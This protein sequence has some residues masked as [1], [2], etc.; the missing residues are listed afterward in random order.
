[1]IYDSVISTGDT[2]I[3]GCRL[4]EIGTDTYNI[5]NL[6]PAGTANSYSYNRNISTGQLEIKLSVNSQTFLHEIPSTGETANEKVFQLTGAGQFFTKTEQDS[7]LERAKLNFVPSTLTRATDKLLYNIETGG[8]FAGTGDL[9]N[10][11]KTGI[12][13]QY[14]DKFFTDFD[15]FL[16]GQKVYSGRGVALPAGVGGSSFKPS[17]RTVEGEVVTNDNKNEFK[18]TAYKKRP[19]VISITGD[20]PDIYGEPFIEKRTNHYINGMEQPQSSYL[21]LYTGVTIIESGISAMTSGGI[22]GTGY[23]YITL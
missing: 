15:Y 18:Y 16:N 8:I 17:F 12:L 4:S 21:E 3:S 23:H 7:S 13:A 1:M 10:S 22:D 19:R 14:Q 9:G 2:T 6:T 5:T 20:S 11:L